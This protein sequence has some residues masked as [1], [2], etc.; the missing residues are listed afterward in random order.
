[1]RKPGASAPFSSNKLFRVTAMVGGSAAG[2]PPGCL[3]S[4][5]ISPHARVSI[6]LFAGKVSDMPKREKRDMSIQEIF[7]LGAGMYCLGTITG[8][9]L[10]YRN[11]RDEG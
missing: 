7:V 8:M 10:R 6:Q 5:R 2:L 9:I 3:S 4:G 1:M 11:P